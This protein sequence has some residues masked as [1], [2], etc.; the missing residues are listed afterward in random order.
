MSRRVYLTA[1][2]SYTSSFWR[3]VC[4]QRLSFLGPASW[5]RLFQIDTV[6]TTGLES[7]T[8]LLK[9]IGIDEVES[10]AEGDQ[11]PG[12]T[13]FSLID[14]VSDAQKIISHSKENVSRVVSF[15]ERF[16]DHL[17]AFSLAEA[18]KGAEFESEAV[19]L[20]RAFSEFDSN[21]INQ[22]DDPRVLAEMEKVI[23]ELAENRDLGP[24]DVLLW[25]EDQERDL[26]KR[27]EGSLSLD[28][29]DVQDLIQGAWSADQSAVLGVQETLYDKA[30]H[31]P[32]SLTWFH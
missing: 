31:F 15:L 3:Y 17:A 4:S 9:S 27:L 5:R 2:I 26:T 18:Q 20:S 24:T 16:D 14:T 10:H 6:I 7:A 32:S 28:D 23:Q 1:E 22:A 13:K 29:I 19:R 30:S 21:I 12:D 11:L 8:L 25:L